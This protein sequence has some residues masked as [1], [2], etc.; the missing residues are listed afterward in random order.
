MNY[1]TKDE[2]ACPCCGDMYL[3]PGFLDALNAVRSRYGHP[4]GVTSGCRCHAHNTVIRGH[5]RSLHVFGNKA[6]KTDT[7][8]VDISVT[9]GEKR[10]ALVEAALAEGLSVGVASNFIHIDMRQAAGLKRRLYHYKR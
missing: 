2:L 8:A 1:F 10:A 9:D 7:C 4:M 3:Q 6:H 5:E